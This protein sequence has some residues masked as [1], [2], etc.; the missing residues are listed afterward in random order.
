MLRCFTS[1]KIATVVFNN[2]KTHQ[3][4]ANKLNKIRFFSYNQIV[5]LSI[6]EERG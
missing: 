3:L 2:E 4:I 5:A 1:F 6:Q